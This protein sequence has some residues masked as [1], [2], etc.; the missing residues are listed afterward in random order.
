MSEAHRHPRG[1]LNTGGNRN[2]WPVCTDVKLSRYV[3]RLVLNAT[4]HIEDSIRSLNQNM[5]IL[6]NM[7]IRSRE[8]TVATSIE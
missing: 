3:A 7:Q 4:L 5:D 8:A 2:Y 1:T 6:L